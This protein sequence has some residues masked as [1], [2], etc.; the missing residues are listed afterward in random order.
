[1]LGDAQRRPVP[2]RGGAH[3]GLRYA[4]GY[5]AVIWAVFFINTV[6][7]AGQLNAFGIRPRDTAGLIGI[8][9]A[10][11]LHGGVDHIVSN[12]IPGAIFCFLV[13]APSRRTW[14]EVS[15]I[16]MLVSGIGTWCFGGVGTIHVGASGMI[17]GWL[18]Y[19]VVRGFF[20]RS[21]R[22]ILLGVVLGLFYSSLVWGV[23]PLSE[24]VSWQAHLFGA[25]G[26]VLAGL[27]I[28][29]DDPVRR[30]YTYQP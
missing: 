9:C 27:T 6:F 14:W 10:P 17:Y 30:E 16:V 19:L 3:V 23:L 26:G 21:F 11:F 12:S 18:A 28:T 25:V 8:V 13:A 29:S 2:Q 24:G 22:Q 15:L 4:V 1:M 20:N 7:F 5:L